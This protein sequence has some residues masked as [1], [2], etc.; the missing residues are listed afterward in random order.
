[1]NTKNDVKQSKKNEDKKY[2][3]ASIMQLFLF[4]FNNLSTNL[5]YVIIS[6]Y[7]LFYAQSY[8]MLSAVIIGWIITAMRAFDGITDPIIGFLI[9]KTDTKFGKFRPWMVIGNIIINLSFIVMFTMI[10][11][12]WSSFS[13]LLV[14]VGFYIIHIIGYSMQTASTKGGGTVISSDPKQRPILAAFYGSFGMI[15]LM[16]LMAIIPQIAQQYPLNMLDPG[17][18]Q[19]ITI[20][21]V[22][23]SFVTML[24]AVAG[25]W[26]KDVP[27]N[28]QS[29]TN[30]K[31]K[32]KDFLS[33]I[34]H[35][36][37]I[38]M[39]IIAASTDKLAFAMSGAVTVYFYANVIMNQDLQSIMSLI[40]VPITIVFVLIG[41]VIGRKT[42]QKKTFVA[43]TWVSL[44]LSVA[45]LLLFP[46]TGAKL[47]SFTVMLYFIIL[48]LR[49]GAINVPGSF[50]TTMISDCADYEVY[51]T[52]R[53]VPGMMGTLFSFIDK[54]I[55]SLNGL[56]ISVMFGLFALQNTVITPLTPATDYPGLIM[57][58]KV[59]LFILPI[60]GFIASIIAMKYYPLTKE[61]MNEVRDTIAAYKENDVAE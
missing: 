12:E 13:K 9:D 7:L 34:K 23:A 33:I 24:M 28:Y 54:V 55:S 11:V 42:T 37:A 22:V 2:N 20:I 10:N 8:L 53:A 17:F 52:G 59:G 30:T 47:S 39:L 16:V 25:I 19:Q 61:K 1:M 43:I 38:S 35:N 44:I 5:P 48:A 50:V 14:F 51:L 26:K 32:F 49:T 29:F 57:I 4:S 27:E 31:V 18:W 21:T 3:R 6:S 41:L 46:D 56:V 58:I 60:F 36:K 15:A 45:G 40:G